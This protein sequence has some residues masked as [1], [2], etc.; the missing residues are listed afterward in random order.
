MKQEDEWGR[1][2]REAEKWWEYTWAKKKGGSILKRRKKWGEY[3]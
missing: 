1:K 3:T 2:L